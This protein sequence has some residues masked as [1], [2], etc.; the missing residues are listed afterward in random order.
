MEAIG[1][2]FGSGVQHDAG[3][4][5]IGGIGTLLDLELLQGIDGSVDIGTALV[6]VGDIGAVKLEGGL[7]ATDAADGGA[8]DVV[9]SDAEEVAATR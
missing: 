6:M 5:E 1:A 7:A 8:G 2:G 3:V 9:G 4:G